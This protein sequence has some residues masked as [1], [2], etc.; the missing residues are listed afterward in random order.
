VSAGPEGCPARELRLNVHPVGAGSHPGAWRYPGA[1]PLAVASIEGYLDVARV[2]ERGKL[3]A[4]FLADVPG[5]HSDLTTYP[6]LNGLE[7]TLI[8]TAMAVVTERIGLVATASTTFNEPFNIAR[9]LR[10]L[11]LISHGRAGWNAVTTSDPRVAANFAAT[12]PD[13]RTRYERAEEF[14][15]VVLDLWQSWQPGAVVADTRSGLYADMSQIRPIGHVGEHF[16]VRGPISLPPSEQGYPVIFHAGVSPD[17]RKLTAR[18]GEAMFGAVCDMD[19]A[20]REATGIRAGA[21]ALGRPAPLLLPGLMTT[22]GGTEQDA[23]DR[24]ATLDDLAG[25][26]DGVALLAYRL[27]VSPDMLELDKPVPEVLLG[28]LGNVTGHA[29]PAAALAGQGLTVRDIL[30]RGGGSGHVQAIGTPDQVASQIE[31]WHASTAVDGFTVMP[32]VTVD[33]LPDFVDH[34]V[35]ILQRRGLFRTEYRGE[36][37]RDHYGLPVPDVAMRRGRQAARA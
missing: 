12:V 28:G 1:D 19:T 35:P 22:L 30:H 11:D 18:T 15:A 23:L 26:D 25:T 27:G 33:G 17:V 34:V 14:V 24:R 21:A 37:L 9:R 3:D 16:S 36:T 2:A 13:S 5:L 6:I 8:L 10:A 32:D 20:L 29:R 31:A 4:I 7:P